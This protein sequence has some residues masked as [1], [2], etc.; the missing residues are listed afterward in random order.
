MTPPMAEPIIDH[1]REN[2]FFILRNKI[3]TVSYKAKFIWKQA[4]VIDT[5]H[6]RYTLQNYYFPL[7]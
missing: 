2:N 5:A 4:P 3:I 1:T 6:F 7:C